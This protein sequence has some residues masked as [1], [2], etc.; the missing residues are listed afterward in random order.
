MELSVN[1]IRCTLPQDCI[2]YI[3]RDVVLLMDF[4]CVRER[5]AVLPKRIYDRPST[6]IRTLVTNEIFCG[7][8]EI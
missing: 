4:K 1:L 5:Q 7:A 3:P 8:F 2:V 6:C